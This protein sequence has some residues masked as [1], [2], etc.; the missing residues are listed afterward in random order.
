MALPL[1]GQQAVV[2]V[3]GE[4]ISKPYIEIT[5]NL[6]ARFGVSVD[7]EGWQ[8]FT[9]PA[10]NQSRAPGPVFVDGDASTASS[11]LAAGAIGTG[12]K[13][14]NGTGQARCQGAEGV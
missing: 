4:L 3:M 11:F 7:R 10:N 9:I 2:E 14:V 8:R 12:P 5:L 13:R 6:M 1:T